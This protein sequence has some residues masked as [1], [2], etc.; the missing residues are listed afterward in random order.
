MASDPTKRAGRGPAEVDSAHTLPPLKSS[1]EVAAYLAVSVLGVYR[2]LRTGRLRGHK[3]G[4]K[5]RV[6]DDA[7]REYLEESIY[8]PRKRK[9]RK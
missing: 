6:S 2:R 9:S 3:I 5:W 8:V 1:E 7:V 4:G